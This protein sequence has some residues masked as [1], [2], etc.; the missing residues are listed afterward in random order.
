MAQFT[1]YSVVLYS[2]IQIT[3][4]SRRSINK[5]IEEHIHRLGLPVAVFV[6]LD[7]FLLPQDREEFEK[8]FGIPAAQGINTDKLAFF[9]D[10]FFVDSTSRCRASNPTSCTNLFTGEM[11]GGT[12]HQTQNNVASDKTNNT[13]ITPGKDAEKGNKLESGCLVSIEHRSIFKR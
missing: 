10:Y 11:V 7:T 2:N 6:C 1:E 8:K 13:N 4:A 5:T 12:Y 9:V 3:T